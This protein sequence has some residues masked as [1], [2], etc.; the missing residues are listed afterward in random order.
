MRPFR[1]SG[2][3]YYS[4]GVPTSQSGAPSR[5]GDILQYRVVMEHFLNDKHGL[6]YAIEVMGIHGLDWRADGQSVTA[7]KTSFGLLGAQPTIE[8]RFTDHIVGAGGVLFTVAGY[9]DIAAIYPNSIC[10]LL[11]E[12]DGK[13]GPALIRYR[14]PRRANPS[15]DSAPTRAER[16]AVQFEIGSALVRY[17]ADQRSA[18]SYKIRRFVISRTSWNGSLRS[19]A[20]SLTKSRNRISG[21]RFSF[22]PPN[23]M[24]QDL[25]DF[26]AWT[27]RGSAIGSPSRQRARES[28]RVPTEKIRGISTYA[29]RDRQRSTKEALHRASETTS[30]RTFCPLK[31]LHHL[32]R[33]R[34]YRA[35]SAVL[36]RGAHFARHRRS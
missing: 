32:C 33:L 14:R 16:S 36:D 19:V 2:G 21:R 20:S 26:A 29:P 3:L 15:R 24:K 31:I 6:G 7:G 27:R 28:D 8:Y 4:Y 23:G 1:F 9:Q 12:H 5:Y 18:A 34:Q 25:Q 13:S 35:S 22:A 30:E 10:L 11:L 17:Q